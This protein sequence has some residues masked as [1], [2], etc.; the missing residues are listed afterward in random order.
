MG[1]LKKLLDW[2]AIKWDKKIAKANLRKMNGSLEKISS[3]I[4]CEINKLLD[5]INW[6]NCS[7]F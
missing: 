4:I 6:L 2:V 7:Y 3:D 1:K 5:C